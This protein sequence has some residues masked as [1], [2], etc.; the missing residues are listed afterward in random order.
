MQKLL[1]GTL[2]IVFSLSLSAQ[3]TKDFFL[4]TDNFL[5]TYVSDGKVNYKAIHESPDALNT[6]LSNAAGIKVARSDKNTYMA[7]WIN[8]YNLTVIK[9]IVADY[10][11]NS[12]LDKPGFFDKTTYPLGGVELSLNQIEDEYL[13]K[14]FNDA[15]IHFVLVCGA[16]GCPPIIEKAY[17]PEN[18]EQLLSLQTSK[19]LDNPDFIKE[20][21]KKLVLSE[22]FKWY[23]EDFGKTDAEVISF[24]NKHKK[25]AVDQG[26]KIEYYPYNWK[27]NKQF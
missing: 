10:P 22:I 2:F 24:I 18:V 27:L 21:G 6:I 16:L 23:R 4:K 14:P 5:S 12:P 17:T 11:I 8:V 13:R 1:L 26:K 7:F 25:I 3:T 9:G 20:K 19:A 15:R